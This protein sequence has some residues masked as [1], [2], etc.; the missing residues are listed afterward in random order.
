MSLKFGVGALIREANSRK[1]QPIQWTAVTGPELE[2]AGFK[3]SGP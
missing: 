3:W 2:E 1:Y